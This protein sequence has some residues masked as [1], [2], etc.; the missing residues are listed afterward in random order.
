MQSKSRILMRLNILYVLFF[1]VVFTN[2][3]ITFFNEH[4]QKHFKKGF[5]EGFKRE[6]MALG[7]EYVQ[8]KSYTFFHIPA[9]NSSEESL[10]IPIE[11]ED[12]TYHVSMQVAE[13][14]IYAQG[15]ELP[16]YPWGA[17]LLLFV[18]AVS[19]LAVFVILFIILLSLRQCIK[20]GNVFNRNNIYLIRTIG[21]LLIVSAVAYNGTEALEQQMVSSIL[22]GS[23][24]SVPS[25][26][27]SFKDAIT[28]FLILIIA[29]IFNI[30]YDITQEQK[31]TI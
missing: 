5:E 12:T 22:E 28:G 1:L 21:I 31:L 30:G 17:T 23:S 3:S 18:Y 29:E 8:T 25:Q 19:N 2:I 14:N 7:E 16:N 13:L 27:F 11:T 6:A 10:S 9:E 26:V 20:K 4:F 24:W 15:K